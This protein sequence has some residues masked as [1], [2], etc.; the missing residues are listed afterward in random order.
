MA[1]Q[2]L[3]RGLRAPGGHPVGAHFA[4]LEG[5]ELRVRVDRCLRGQACPGCA[6]WSPDP[7]EGQRRLRRLRRQRIPGSSADEATP[8]GAVPRCVNRSDRTFLVGAA[9][10]AASA[11]LLAAKALQQPACPDPVP[12]ALST[13]AR[14]C[15]EPASG[16]FDHYA[17]Q[18]SL[19]GGPWSLGPQSI[20]QE[21]E[22]SLPAGNLLR[23]GTALRLR[24]GAALAPKPNV[25]VIYSWSESSDPVPV[26]KP[27]DLD[28]DGQV[29]L[30][31]F[32]SFRACFGSRAVE[33]SASDLNAD[34]MVGIPDFMLFR[35]QFGR[36]TGG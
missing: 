23:P 1:H 9:I 18:V 25:Q 36:P 6:V 33:C 22:V 13:G 17:T 29:G 27:A 8:V 2:D 20:G 14:Y 3:Q 10:A 5:E 24:A 12:F 4:D 15:W 11:G 21:H 31:D 35:L 28:G 16:D 32:G 7:G 34:G 19:D 26:S 30:Q